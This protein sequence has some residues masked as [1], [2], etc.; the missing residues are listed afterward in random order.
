MRQIHRRRDAGE[1]LIEILIA[2]VI[3]GITATGL[4]AGL[5]TGIFA[6]DAHR[7]ISSA[8]S[9]LRAYGEL[10]KDKVIH[11]AS[12][13]TTAD[14]TTFADGDNLTIPV[15]STAGFSG[16]GDYTISLD[17]AIMKVKS[18]TSDSFSVT[19]MAGGTARSGATVQRYESCPDA[20][21]FDDV[22]TGHSELTT[23]DRLAAPTVS[24][25]KFYDTSNTLVTDCPGYHSSA[26]QSSCSLGTDWR[27]ECDPAWMRVTVSVVS[28]DAG[29]SKASVSTDV[30]VRRVS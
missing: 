7:R 10:V 19:A 17:G 16:T 15:D 28:T 1:T 9:V 25:V 6:T 30:I 2:I 26:G 24:A 8:E 3:I 12:T 18:Q 11:P 23:V 22:L 27:T 13:T 4:I 29:R 14:V 21:Y 20:G 5:S